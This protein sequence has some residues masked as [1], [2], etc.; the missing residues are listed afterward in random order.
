MDR[1]S[2]AELRSRCKTARQ[3]R[4]FN[5]LVKSFADKEVKSINELWDSLFP[6][7]GK[8][9][10]GTAKING[11]KVTVK[12]YKGDNV[13]TGSYKL[14]VDGEQVDSGMCDLKPG[15]GSRLSI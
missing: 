4:A 1:K 15:F 14:I 8:T 12:I 13:A 7:E 2:F 6:F 5:E 10:Q 11:K 3:M 9:K